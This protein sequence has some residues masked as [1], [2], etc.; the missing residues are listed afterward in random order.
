[1]TLQ[2][3][4]NWCPPFFPETAVGQR[5]DNIFALIGNAQ[6]V[7][8]KLSWPKEWITEFVKTAMTAKSYDESIDFI[9]QY[10]RV[11]DIDWDFE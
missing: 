1:M 10:F 5:G 4:T 2:M 11:K 9:K 7:A 3:E 8:K 6:Y